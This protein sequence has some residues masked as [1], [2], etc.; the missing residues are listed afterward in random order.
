[1]T[2]PPPQ[3]P[4]LS[5]CVP[6]YNRGPWLA[7]RVRAWLEAAPPSRIEVVVSDNASTDGTADAVAAVS[8]PR[9]VLLRGDANVGAFENQL[10]AFEAARG[11]YVMQ[12]TD[13]DELMPGGIAPALAAL[14][15]LDVA[16][17]EFVLNGCGTSPEA[18][19][20]SRGFAAFRRHGLAF[21]HPSGHFFSSAALR[22]FGL[23]ARLR[24]L[25]PA[26]RPYST[27]YLV[28]LALRHGPY[29]AVDVPFVRM[30][31]PPYEGIAASVS[32]RDPS[33]YYFTP[34]FLVKEFA[35]YIGFLRR[36]SRMPALQ[37]LRLVA[38]LAGGQVFSQM[39]AWY[40]WRLESDAL[41]EWYGMDPEFRRRERGR[42]LERD[43]ADALRG[44]AGVGRLERFAVRRGVAGRLRRGGDYEIPSNVKGGA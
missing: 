4:L 2:E 11:R 43:A 39:T 40:R 13:K 37:R 16:C 1:M 10:R 5:V 7:G 35:E 36:E 14:S 18:V 29:A 42:D 24:A 3:P 6:T 17:G 33:E 20:V 34:P 30:N 15:G 12:L 25:D 19:R 26:V 28:S 9:L 32:Y 44:I 41:C 22:K 8:D 38:R 21:T 27:D 31:K 23:L